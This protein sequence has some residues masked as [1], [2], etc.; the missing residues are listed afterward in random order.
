MFAHV[1]GLRGHV[2]LLFSHPDVRR[3]PVKHPSPQPQVATQASLIAFR[4]KTANRHFS[5]SLSKIIRTAGRNPNLLLH[6]SGTRMW[7]IPSDPAVVA[8][9][10]MPPRFYSSF[11]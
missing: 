8:L 3:L 1:C 10:A 6:R 11:A 5:A 2:L 7:L 4:R 9:G